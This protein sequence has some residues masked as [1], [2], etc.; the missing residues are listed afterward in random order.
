MS[1]EYWQICFLHL[2]DSHFHRIRIYSSLTA[3]ELWNTGSI[4]NEFLFKE[5]WRGQVKVYSKRDSKW[6]LF[7]SD[8]SLCIFYSHF[9]G[10][11]RTK[12]QSCI[13]RSTL[14]ITSSGLLLWPT[15]EMTERT[16]WL[17]KIKH[18]VKIWSGN[19]LL[20]PRRVELYF[21]VLC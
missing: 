1:K 21:T 18:W 7:I 17:N 3:M 12:R 2:G 16:D 20:K 19:E 15:W 6:M 9:W 10:T 14:N 11:V 5:S 13:D 8:F 4:F